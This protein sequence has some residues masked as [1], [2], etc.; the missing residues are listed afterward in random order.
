MEAHA[1]TRASRV[2][3][4]YC[5]GLEDLYAAVRSWLSSSGFRTIRD[6]TSLHETATG[7]Y[8]APVLRIL[9]K[10]G[11]H[12][13]TLMPKGAWIIGAKGRVDLVGPMDIQPILLLA[14]GGP[15]LTTTTTIKGEEIER[16]TRPFFK[17]V[18][19]EGWYYIDDSSPAIARHLT[20]DA[21]LSLLERVA[22]YEARR[23]A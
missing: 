16:H 7:R 14:S 8:Q 2:R 22:G 15:A 21:F 20:K 13:A 5:R 3:S 10:D 17:G 12:L 9:R 6:T 4:E 19:R 1:T 18:D 23:S 11:S